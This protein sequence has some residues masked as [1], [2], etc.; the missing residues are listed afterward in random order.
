VDFIAFTSMSA[1]HQHLDRQQQ[2]MDQQQRMHEPGRIDGVRGKLSGC[3]SR[4]QHRA[5]PAST[6]LDLDQEV[7][8]NGG[9]NLGTQQ[10]AYGHFRRGLP[11]QRSTT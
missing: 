5:V 6:K 10:A 3:R 8:R 2:R 9:P 1:Q 7:L 11:C 4:A